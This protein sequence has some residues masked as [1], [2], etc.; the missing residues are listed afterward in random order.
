MCEGTDEGKNIYSNFFTVLQTGVSS[1]FIYP[2]LDKLVM[3]QFN[4]TII[5]DYK[6]TIINE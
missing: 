1:S 2:Q 5:N 6:K 3:T 4:K